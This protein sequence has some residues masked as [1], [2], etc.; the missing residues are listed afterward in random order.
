V[1]ALTF[2][3]FP[4]SPVEWTGGW[5]YTSLAPITVAAPADYLSGFWS[6][7]TPLVR[8]A[9]YKTDTKYLPFATDFTVRV[10]LDIYAKKYKA[11]WQ[12]TKQPVAW[13]AS[14]TCNNHCVEIVPTALEAKS[15]RTR[16][17]VQAKA[18]A[19]K[20]LPDLT[21][22]VT[23]LLQRVYH[24]SQAQTVF[25]SDC[26]NSHTDPQPVASTFA[27]PKYFWLSAGAP[28]LVIKNKQDALALNPKG[29]VELAGH[30]VKTIHPFHSND[31]VPFKPDNPLFSINQVCRAVRY[32]NEHCPTDLF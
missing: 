12:N 13:K 31:I 18:A 6:Y 22:W 11:G 10:V 29:E 2:K 28:F 26:Q 25:V 27:D 24:P 15:R 14:V 8:A 4:D 3:G 21:P 20:L 32:V 23:V 17:L 7:C 16:S 1:P 19:P 30:I 5:K 9:A